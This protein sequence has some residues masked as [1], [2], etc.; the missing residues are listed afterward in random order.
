MMTAAAFFSVKE[1]RLKDL[2]GAREEANPYE[3]FCQEAP[4]ALPAACRFLKQFGS[5]SR[6]YEIEALS[7]HLLFVYIITFKHNNKRKGL[8]YECSTVR[9]WVACPVNLHI[10]G[11]L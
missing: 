11:R 4:F 5:K 3:R 9:F 7:A 1:F 6:G 2:Q 10:G 8:I